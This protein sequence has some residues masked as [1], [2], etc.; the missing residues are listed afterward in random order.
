M[1]SLIARYTQFFP[2]DKTI[3]R[4]LQ[5]QRQPWV[6]Q[7]MIA[8][9]EPGFPGIGVPLTFSIAAI[10]WALRFRLEALFI[11]L[12]SSS[13]ILNALVKRLIK[14]PRPTQE[15]VTVASAWDQ[16]RKECGQAC[17]ADRLSRGRQCLA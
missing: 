6:R 1:I 7:F 15:L 2:G 3:T 16:Q 17:A 12:T 14:R 13:N 5:R 4:N 10:F 9:S 8:I 11:L